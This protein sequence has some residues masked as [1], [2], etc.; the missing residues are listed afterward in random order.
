V[1]P[2]GPSALERGGGPQHADVVVAAAYDL[3]PDG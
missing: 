3:E 1:L 2:P